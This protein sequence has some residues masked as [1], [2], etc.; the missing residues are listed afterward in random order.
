M[1]KAPKWYW[2]ASGA[3]LLWAL[4][5]CFFYYTQVSMTADDL[6][7]LPQVQRDIWTL[8]P[9]WVVGAYAVAVWSA[10]AGAV[11]LL[12]RRR[13]A[14]LLFFI[15]LIG[16]AVQFGWT[17][18]ATPLLAG[19]IVCWFVVQTIINVGGVTGLKRGL[20]HHDR[21]H[22]PDKADFRPCKRKMGRSERARAVRVEDFRARN[23][24]V[25]GTVRWVDPR[26]DDHG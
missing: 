15:S 20:R 25:V 9:K 8:M 11:G 2:W 21:D 12:L 4:T 6:A 16:I 13:W 3:A 1:H 23:A 17:F 26:A 22:F 5:G 18:M 14:L 10:L 7:K 24:L 19:G